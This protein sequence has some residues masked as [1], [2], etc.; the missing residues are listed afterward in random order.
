MISTLK[1]FLLM[2]FYYPTLVLFFCLFTRNTQIN[3]TER[4]VFPNTAQMFG[5][6]PFFLGYSKLTEIFCS[7]WVW[8]MTF[9]IIC[10]LVDY[11]KGTDITYA[12]DY[13]ML[14]TLHALVQK[15]SRKR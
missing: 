7:D 6:R 10:D 15:L 3:S 5:C 9:R 8:L 11:F 13:S 14:C 12:V 2:R 1:N 4:T